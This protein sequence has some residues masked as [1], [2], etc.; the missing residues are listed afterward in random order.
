MDTKT[1][2]I[3]HSDSDLAV[4]FSENCMNVEIIHE[5]LA[6]NDIPANVK[7]QLMGSIA[8]WQVSAGGFEPVVVEVL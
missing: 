4:V 8:S 3:K 6:D 2:W 5:I 1:N 7:N